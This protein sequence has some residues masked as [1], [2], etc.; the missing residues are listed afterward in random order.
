MISIDPGLNGTGWAIWKK[1]NFLVT[2]IICPP[3]KYEWFDRARMITRDLSILV[4]DNGIENMHI[5]YPAYFGSVGGRMV[6]GGGG[7]VKLAFLTGMICGRAVDLD[8]KI[9]LVEVNKWKG[10]LPKKIVEARIKK[11]L[12][13]RT[14]KDF[15]THIYDAVGI[16]L[17][18]QGRF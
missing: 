17:W 10:Q 15:K 5:E 14:T 12:G 9:N 7:L 6:A 18:A 11:I 2:G 16:G 13:K 1:G 4:N 8:L 3:K